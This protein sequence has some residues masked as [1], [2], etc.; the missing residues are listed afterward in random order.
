MLAQLM[1]DTFKYGSANVL[2]ELRVGVDVIFCGGL[3]VEFILIL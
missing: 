1:L 3:V 2:A